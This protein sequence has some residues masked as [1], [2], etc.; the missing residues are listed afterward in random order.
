MVEV[1]VAFWPY[2]QC[3]HKDCK[4]RLLCVGHVC[5][6][7]VFAYN[8]SLYYI[9]EYCY[10][11]WKSGSYPHE[12]SAFY[13]HMV[14]FLIS[15]GC[16]NLVHLS[17]LWKGRYYKMEMIKMVLLELLGLILIVRIH[18]LEIRYLF[19]CYMLFQKLG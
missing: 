3:T 18:R 5:S 9:W 13:T 8:E 17:H 15:K 16:Q 14:S 10:G 6:R 7:S 2:T 11:T 19:I 12:S 4:E 1:V